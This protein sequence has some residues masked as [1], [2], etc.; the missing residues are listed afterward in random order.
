MLAQSVAPEL[1][2]LICG[3]LRLWWRDPRGQRILTAGEPEDGPGYRMNTEILQDSAVVRL[4]QLVMQRFG[5]TFRVSP[6]LDL[7]NVDTEEPFTRLG[8]DLHIPIIVDHNF[9][10]TVIVQEVDDLESKEYQALSSLVKMVMDPLFQSWY[11]EHQKNL[12]ELEIEKPYLSSPNQKM[13]DLIPIH[14]E[15]FLRD[16]SFA[17]DFAEEPSQQEAARV[18]MLQSINPQM[19]MRAANQ[20]HEMTHR[21]AFVP[22]RDIRS[23]I[24]D[25]YDLR[26]MG[27][28]TLFVPDILQLEVNDLRILKEF[29][30]QD[31]S[32]DD[33]LLILGS[34]SSLDDLRKNLIVDADLHRE[35]SE[36][37]VE[38]DR[39]PL[40]YGTL[41]EVLD[42]LLIDLN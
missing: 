27:A 15:D 20:I 31:K 2:L 32:S 37:H 29:I 28:M 25:V 9:L 19:L 8:S 23:Q 3:G 33:P 22:F 40:S 5:K 16:V 38:I 4:R 10:S 35:L 7:K 13:A 41:K 42:L 17:S 1:L 11:L 30:M 18:I 26:Q 24:M 34:S 12:I 14:R 21:W 36:V 6:L 39:V